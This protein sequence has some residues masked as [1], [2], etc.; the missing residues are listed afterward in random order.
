M[1]S[2][3]WQ[4]PFTFALILEL[5]SAGSHICFLR[6][7]S[8]IYA[9]HIKAFPLTTDTLGFPS[10]Q[11]EYCVYEEVQISETWPPEFVRILRNIQIFSLDL[12]YQRSPSKTFPVYLSFCEDF[13]VSSEV[14]EISC[15]PLFQGTRKEML[16]SISFIPPL[17]HLL[18]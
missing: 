18:W 2:F 14:L 5:L 15:W 6:N 13:V 17:K 1:F 10:L 9:S 4:P 11:S 7:S 8:F 12:C 16:K 3:W